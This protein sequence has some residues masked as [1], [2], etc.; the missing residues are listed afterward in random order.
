MAKAIARERM[1]KLLDLAEK[2]ALFGNLERGR[3]YV[4][5]ARRIGM[6]TN[7]SVPK[8]H[9]FCKTCHSP[10]VPGRNCSVR[11]RSG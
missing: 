11:L 4:Y 3:K 5:L 7:T 9:L 6:R 8:G 10:L 2:E 1:E